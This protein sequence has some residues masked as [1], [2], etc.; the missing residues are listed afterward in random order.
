[1]NSY[2][3]PYQKQKLSYTITNAECDIK[4]LVS[5]TDALE[6]ELKSQE[7]E[8]SRLNER[9]DQLQTD[10]WRALL[11]CK[12]LK[13]R[14]DILEILILQLLQPE[15]FKYFTHTVIDAL[16]NKEVAK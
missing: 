16:S 11:L 7:T 13:Q 8:I 12:I 10:E 3:P 5:K 1:M 14:L 6:S 2:N 4:Q 15:G 9:V